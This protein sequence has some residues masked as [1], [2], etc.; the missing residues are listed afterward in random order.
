M[1]FFFM[2]AYG[3]EKELPALKGIFLDITDNPK[4]HF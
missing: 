1:N 2:V 3:Q 4:C